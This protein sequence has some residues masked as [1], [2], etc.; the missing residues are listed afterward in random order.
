MDIITDISQ[1]R[2]EAAVATIGFFDGVHLGHRYLLQ[3]VTDEAARRKVRSMAITFDNHPRHTL[4]AD[5]KPQLITTLH[6]KLALL[7]DSGL[8]A[9]AVLPFTKEMAQL[10]AYQ[11]MEQYLKQT[12]NV[13]CLIIGYDHR[14]G[15]N[16]SE[17]FI[18]YVEY[19]HALGID[20]VRAGACDAADITVSSSAVRRFLEAGNIDK[21]KTCLGRPYSLSGIVVEGHKVGRN[22]GFPTA[23]IQAAPEKII[24]GRGVYA[25]WVEVEEKRYAAMLNIG[26]RPTV[27]NGANSTIEVHLFDFEGDLYGKTLTLSFESRLRDEQKFESLEALQLQLQADK[28]LARNILLL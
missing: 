12:L 26:W 8:D 15:N 28:K 18:D 21:V 17:S 6:E 25:V 16:R 7:E 24:P 23:N 13:E 3:Q 27:N 4:C 10:S 9:C 5:Y 22:L 20:V 11:F 14:F 1:H 2:G 19:G